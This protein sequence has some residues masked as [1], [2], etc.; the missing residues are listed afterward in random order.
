M[1]VALSDAGRSPFARD[2]ARHAA[3]WWAKV[4]RPSTTDSASVRRISSS[5]EVPR[6]WARLANASTTDASKSLIVSSAMTGPALALAG[7]LHSTATPPWEI[8]TASR[9]RTVMAE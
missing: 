3:V 9:A 2:A 7:D 4:S 5:N 6:A 8:L 1:K